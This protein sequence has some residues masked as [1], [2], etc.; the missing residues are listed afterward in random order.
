MSKPKD[1]EELS[2]ALRNSTIIHCEHINLHGEYDFTKLNTLKNPM[3]DMAK[4]NQL[5]F[6]KVA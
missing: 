1:I 6:K 4:I 3:F 2:V 5:Q